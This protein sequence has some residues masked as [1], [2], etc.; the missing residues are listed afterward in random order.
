MTPLRILSAILLLTLSPWT[1]AQDQRD[2]DC[3][4]KH[5]SAAVNG[6][7]PLGF[8]ASEA[9]QLIERVARAIGLKLD[10]V[11]VPCQTLAKA[12][13]FRQA[14]GL[15]PRNYLVYDPVWVREVT[16]KSK[17]RAIG[18]IG[19]ELGHFLNAHFTDR[20]QV[21][22]AEKEAEADAFAGCAIARLTQD[23]EPLEDL[24]TALRSETASVLYPDRFKSIE[25]AKAGYENC[26]GVPQSYTAVSFAIQPAQSRAEDLLHA[27]VKETI[28]E[29]FSKNADL[30]KY[31]RVEYLPYGSVVPK[32]QVLSAVRQG[33]LKA[34][35][36]RSDARPQTLGFATISCGA[37]NWLLVNPDFWRSLPDA[38]AAALVR[39]CSG[40]L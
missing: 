32:D 11:A 13:T 39:V 1:Q 3:V 27:N 12:Y 16:G 40:P 17:G 30:S 18:L 19:H 36:L 22:R 28:A 23:F 15:P 9:E 10:V 35:M 2:I 8:S 20:K 14:I 29:R 34:T 31:L 37:S 21:P 6:G 4:R 24:L 26:S 7:A 33:V 25:R 5:L 38:A